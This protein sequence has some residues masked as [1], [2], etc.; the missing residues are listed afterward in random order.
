MYEIDLR[1]GFVNNRPKQFFC[2][3]T[4]GKPLHLKVRFISTLVYIG[5]R[6]RAPLYLK[7]DLSP[8]DVAKNAELSKWLKQS[9]ISPNDFTAAVSGT[10]KEPPKEEPTFPQ[11]SDGNFHL[12]VTI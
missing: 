8:Q 9:G 12:T 10:Q 5:T 7:F 3:L 6:P 1:T 4:D 2:C 11:N